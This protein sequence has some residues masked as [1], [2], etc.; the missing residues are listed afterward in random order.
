MIDVLVADD[1]AL[2]RDGFR[3]IIDREA[4]M[5]V[6]AEASDGVEAVE[7]TRRHRPHVLLMDIRMPRLDGLVATRRVL[8]LDTPP[9]VLV[10]T[11]FDRNDWVYEALRSGASGFLLK[12]VRGSQLTDAVRVVAAGEALLAPAITGRLIEDFLA[13]HGLPSP[14]PDACPLSVREQ[15]VLRRI[16]LGES[17]SEIAEHLYLGISTVKT[18]VNRLL[19]KLELRDRTQAVVY[20]YEHGIVRPGHLRE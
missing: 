12:D 3:A 5:R 17:N 18:Y 6:V 11:T 9:R 8:A 10:L 2:V 7:L 14:T 15:D 1:Q 16:A 13:R 4:D 20:A 19:T